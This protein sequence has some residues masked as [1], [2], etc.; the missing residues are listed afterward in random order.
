MY[1]YPINKLATTNDMLGYRL[2][3]YYYE[4]EQFII[5]TTDSFDNEDYSGINVGFI[6]DMPN[7]H[8]NCLNYAAS[9]LL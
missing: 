9:D 6:T 5:G 1:Y 7:N 4:M 3:N 8:L 2:V